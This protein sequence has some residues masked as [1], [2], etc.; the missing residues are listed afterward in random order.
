M[1]INIILKSLLLSSFSSLVLAEG[2]KKNGCKEITK[3]LNDRGNGMDED[4]LSCV[5]DADG[6]PTHL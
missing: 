1:K 6:N 4:I 2:V 3:Y 5:A